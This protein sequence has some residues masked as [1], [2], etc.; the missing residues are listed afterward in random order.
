[1]EVVFGYYFFELFVKGNHLRDLANSIIIPLGHIRELLFTQLSP[2]QINHSTDLTIVLQISHGKLIP[3]E[4]VLALQL[5]VKTGQKALEKVFLLSGQLSL[6]GG[7]VSKSLWLN[8]HAS[9]SASTGAHAR[10]EP[11]EML[12]NFYSA[13]LGVKLILDALMAV[14]QIYEEDVVASQYFKAAFSDHGYLT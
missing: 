11:G 5:L 13:F 6:V 9:E 12:L 10:L 1:M 14:A 7:L 2:G 3:A 4:I 8:N